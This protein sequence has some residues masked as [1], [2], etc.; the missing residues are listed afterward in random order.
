VQFL[1]R[2]VVD[3][4]FTDENFEDRVAEMREQLGLPPVD[5]FEDVPD[6][7]LQ[8]GASGQ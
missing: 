7:E 5:D 2:G 4:E 8:R 3:E 6:D 1:A